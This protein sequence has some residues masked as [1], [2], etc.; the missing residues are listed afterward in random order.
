MFHVSLYLSLTYV[1]FKCSHVSRYEGFEAHLHPNQYA[2]APP[3]AGARL[4]SPLGREISTLPQSM[5]YRSA[6]A[7]P[8]F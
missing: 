3:C 5:A 8:L 1:T 7:L 6:H 4:I 2:A